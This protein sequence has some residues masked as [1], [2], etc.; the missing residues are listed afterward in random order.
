MTLDF[1]PEWEK[2]AVLAFLKSAEGSD[3]RTVL[4]GLVADKVGRTF[5]TLLEKEADFPEAWE[6]PEI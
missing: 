6:C 1:L 3:W 4:A 2:E 5:L